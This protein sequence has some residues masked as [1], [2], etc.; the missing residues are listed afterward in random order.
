MLIKGINYV[1]KKKMKLNNPISVLHSV[2]VGSVSSLVR[3]SFVDGLML[4]FYQFFSS[5]NHIVVNYRVK[6][7][8][9]M[10]IF[11]L[12]SGFCE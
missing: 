10:L 11:D 6:E 3:C 2:F 8:I 4:L 7:Y 9:L 12:A 1:Q 5:Q